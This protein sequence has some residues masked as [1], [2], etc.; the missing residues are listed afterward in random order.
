MSPV[1]ARSPESDPFYVPGR[2]GCFVCREIGN[3]RESALEHRDR[4]ASREP[5]QASTLGPTSS[6]I[7]GPDQGRSH[8]LLTGVVSPPDAGRGLQP[9]FRTLE[10]DSFRVVPAEDGRGWLTTTLPVATCLN[11]IGSYPCI[12]GG[13]S[14][15]N[16]AL[17]LLG[18][19]GCECPNPFISLHIGTY[20]QTE[21]SV[22]TGCYT[23]LRCRFQRP[24]S[25]KSNCIAPRR[26]AVRIRLAP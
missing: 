24:F 12:S 21:S 7:G 17:P 16:R 20:I 22:G 5:S 15:L 26:S 14:S 9:R 11:D 4:A 8:A 2:M 18:T 23:A 25:S 10:V 13:R 1:P 6:L 3:R 19:H